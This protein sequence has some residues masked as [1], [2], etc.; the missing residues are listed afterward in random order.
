MTAGYLGM[1]WNRLNWQGGVAA[2][3]N[4]LITQPLT[5]FLKTANIDVG[6]IVAGLLLP[7]RSGADGLERAYR[8]HLFGDATLQD[9]PDPQK[10]K[11]PRFVIL[12][13]DYELNT[14]WRFSKPYAANYRVGMV[15]K[16]TF[17]LATLVAASSAFPPFFCPITLSLKSADLRKMP[18]ADRHAAPYTDRALLADAGIYDNLGLEPIW[19][20]YGTILISNAGDP[21]GEENSPRWWAPVIRRATGMIHRQ[22]ENNRMRWM[23]SLRRRRERVLADWHL[24]E[25]PKRFGVSGSISLSMSE[26]TAAQNESVRLKALSNDAFERLVRHGYSMCDAAVRS[27][28]K[29]HSPP[30]PAW[31]KLPL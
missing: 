26:L 16:P 7:G 11:S 10:G 12:A 21:F 6:N 23:H 14:L 8:K 15:D 29:F 5:R 24:R 20:R 9:F 28:L 19:K 27:N 25:T 18:G 1:N 22:A 13:T 17:P 2:N 31:P 3:F 4:A 30:A